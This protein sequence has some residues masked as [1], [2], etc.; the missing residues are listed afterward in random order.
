M[1]EKKVANT[2]KQ[3]FSKAQIKSAN[4][5]KYN[6]DLLEVLLEEDKEYTLADV[7]KLVGD[8]NKRRIDY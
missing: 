2:A 5:L 8:Y 4:S 3:K 1:T 7:E 6:V